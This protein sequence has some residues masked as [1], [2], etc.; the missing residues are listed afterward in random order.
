M[1]KWRSCLKV[2]YFTAGHARN[3]PCGLNVSVQSQPPRTRL[4]VDHEIM[5]T[6]DGRLKLSLP[7]SLIN[8]APARAARVSAEGV[9][10]E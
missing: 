8:A 10:V 1:C 3:R 2:A 5:T 6:H 4:E 9:Q 7:A